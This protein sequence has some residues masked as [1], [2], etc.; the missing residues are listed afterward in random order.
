MKERYLSQNR[1][2]S[3]AGSSFDNKV[4][5]TSRTEHRTQCN[6]LNIFL[7]TVTSAVTFDYVSKDCSISGAPTVH[8]APWIGPQREGGG[9]RKRGKPK[10]TWR[11]TSKDGLQLRGISWCEVEAA[12]AERT[13]WQYLAAHC[14]TCQEKHNLH[15]FKNN[16]HINPHCA[17]MI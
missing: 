1:D 15:H 8:T 11:T 4:D 7:T 12:A 17:Q 6:R 9:R 3:D 10:E 16:V 5:K 14:L 13:R 2:Q